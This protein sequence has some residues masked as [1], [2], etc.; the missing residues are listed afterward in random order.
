MRCEAI[1]EAWLAARYAAEAPAPDVSEHV[2]SCS[3]CRAFAAGQ[4]K[5]DGLLAQEQPITPGLGFD[6]RFFAKLDAE[7]TR[8]RTRRALVWFAP[9]GLAAALG[10]AIFARPHEAP[11]LPPLEDVA[12]VQDLELV[13]ELPMIRQLDEVEAFETLAQ[14]DTADLDA[15]LREATP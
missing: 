8:S 4:T 13:E 15:V 12:L 14:V 10:L 3:E 6:T 5:L 7:R 9:L 1:Q 11:A 2:A